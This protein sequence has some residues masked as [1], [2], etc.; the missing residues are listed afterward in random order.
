MKIEDVSDEKGIPK[1]WMKVLLHNGLTC[2]MVAENDQAILEHLTDVQVHL[3][4]EGDETGFTLEFHFSPNDY[5]TNT[6]LTKQYIFNHQPPADSP[7]DYDGPEIVKCRGCQITWKQGKNVTIK[8]MKKV[9]K[10]K[11]RK[12]MRTIT[13]TVKRDSFFNFFDPPLDALTDEGIDEDTV[14]L[15][16]E[17]FRIG[18]FMRDSLIPRAVLY[19]TG[20]AVDSD[21]SLV[22]YTLFA[23]LYN[24]QPYPIYTFYFPTT[25]PKCVVPFTFAKLRGQKTDFRLNKHILFSG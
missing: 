12:E 9:K 13:K 1:F 3:T 21:V 23:V 18:H 10:H 25:Y 19:Y 2:E 5:F 11:N 14:E 6:V 7:L 8:V 20:E 15:L 4:T 16:H 22:I 24:I 17:D